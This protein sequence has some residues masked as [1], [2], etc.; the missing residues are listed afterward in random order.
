MSTK[1]SQPARPGPGV[2]GTEAIGASSQETRHRR[3]RTDAMDALLRAVNGRDSYGV[4][5]IE[6]R[7]ARELSARKR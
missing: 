2:T 5:A 7:A 3:G 6:A 4:A 1:P